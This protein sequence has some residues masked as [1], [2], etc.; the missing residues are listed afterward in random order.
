MFTDKVSSAKPNKVPVLQWI[1]EFTFPVQE[2]NTVLAELR[3]RSDTDDVH[4]METAFR[5]FK[6]SE[7]ANSTN[8]C[9]KAYTLFGKA[10]EAM[11]ATPQLPADLIPIWNAMQTQIKQLYNK[12]DLHK[13]YK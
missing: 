5:L 2:F 4:A 12:L 9:M 1:L 13:H 8:A 7:D 3:R 6:K 11:P 10:R